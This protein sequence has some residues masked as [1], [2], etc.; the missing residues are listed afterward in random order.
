MTIVHSNRFRSKAVDSM[1]EDDFSEACAEYDRISP[2]DPWKTS[3]LLKSKKHIASG[4]NEDADL[5]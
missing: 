4:E 3:M 1:S 5:A 2:L